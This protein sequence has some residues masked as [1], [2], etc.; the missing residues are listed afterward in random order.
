MPDGGQLRTPV[1]PRSSWPKAESSRVESS[2]CPSRPSPNAPV[3]AH[4]LIS[5][6]SNFRRKIHSLRDF[7]CVF[8]LNSSIFSAL[9]KA[10]G[11]VVNLSSFPS[12]TALEPCRCSSEV[13]QRAYKSTG[14]GKIADNAATKSNTA[15]LKRSARENNQKKKTRKEILKWER[16]VAEKGNG[17]GGKG[18]VM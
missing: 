18:L 5:N 9:Y 7:G 6:E 4:E 15:R 8:I 11:P 13:I 3:Q 16:K 17:E 2:L 12:L 1:T 14:K 10:L